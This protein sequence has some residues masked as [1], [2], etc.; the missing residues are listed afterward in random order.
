LNA[1]VTG[2]E[3][4]SRHTRD[5]L[6]NPFVLVLVCNVD[7]ILRLQVTLEVVGDK[8]VIAM[9]GDSGDKRRKR[10]LIAELVALDG[11]EDFL[12]AGMDLVLAVKVCMTKIFDIL[13]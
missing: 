9:L 3:A 10:S 8:I 13:G 11:V 1:S 7:Q 5:T 2:E 6:A 12:Q 4:H